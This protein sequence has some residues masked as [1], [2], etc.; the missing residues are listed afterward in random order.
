M[1]SGLA[2][3]MHAAPVQARRHFTPQPRQIARNPDA[4]IPSPDAVG[5]AKPRTA[6]G[7]CTT[8]TALAPYLDT[9]SAPASGG[10]ERRV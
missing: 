1:V 9:A 6:A 7:S 3:A 5:V 8:A 2:Q 10:A 4:A